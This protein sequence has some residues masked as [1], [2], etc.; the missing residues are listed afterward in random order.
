MKA[1]FGTEE[2]VFHVI[3]ANNNNGID[4]HISNYS[5]CVSDDLYIFT[6]NEEFLL[7]TGGNLCFYDFDI[8]LERPATSIRYFNSNGNFVINIQRHEQLG[9]DVFEAARRA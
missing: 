5:D 2:R 9:Q 8:I 6:P 3:E 4:K 7:R 1:F